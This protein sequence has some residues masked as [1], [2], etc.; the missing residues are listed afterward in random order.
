MGK[1]NVVA[2]HLSKPVRLVQGDNNGNW[3]G[4]SK[5][6]IKEMQRAEPRWREMVE[7]LEGG[8]APRSKYPRTALNQFFLEDDVLYLSKQKVDGTILYL[9]VV[10]NEL[11]K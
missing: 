5:E 4:T 1:K 10:P 11:R 2:D 7:Y 6:E 8:R 3:L 9:L